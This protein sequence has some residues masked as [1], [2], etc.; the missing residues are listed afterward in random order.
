[1][2]QIFNIQDDKVVINKLALTYLEGTVNHAGQLNLTGVLNLEGDLKTN[3]VITADTIKV[4]NLIT[5]AGS[6]TE[7]GRWTF[8]TEEELVGKGLHWTWGEGNVNLIY[9]D[10]RRLYT[11][12]NFDLE[13]GFK[14]KIGNVDVLSINELSPQVVKSKLREVGMLKSLAVQGDSI[15]GEFAFF[16]SANSRVGLNTDEPN[17]ALSVVEND[18]EIVI[19]SPAYGKARVG[20]FTSHSLAI[21]TDNTDRIII[22]NSGEVVIGD[23]V[24]KNGNVIINGTLKVDTIIADTRIDRYSPLEFKST[25]DSTIYGKGLLWSGLGATRQLIMLANPDRI[26]TS[27]SF[28]LGAEQAYYI[29]GDAVLSANG[30]GNNITRS[31]LTSVGTLES[32]TVHGTASFAGGVSVTGGTTLINNA[33]FDDSFG[34][35]LSVVSTKLNASTSLSINI[36]EDETYYADSHEI[37]IGNKTNT[38]RPVKMFGPVSI[39]VSNSDPEVDLAVKGNIQFADKKFVTGVHAPLD[40]HYNKGD[41]CWNQ[42][43]APDNYVGWVCIVSGAPGD[44]APFGAIGRR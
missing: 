12:A 9:R 19:G 4:K 14:Y 36:A 17:G 27:E 10:G 20:T 25:R 39:G 23:E 26:W 37:V 22:K 41:I 18:V 29:N 30:L 13:T 34:N 6:P 8:N 15:L 44:W 7:V 35:T 31:N 24:T 16:N 1:M 28:D 11:N 42:D 32:L 3:G 2:A 40:G 43:P 38:R 21:A 33:L 5:E